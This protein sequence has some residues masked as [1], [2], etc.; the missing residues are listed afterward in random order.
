M[1]ILTVDDS[2][3]MRKMIKGAINRLG[4]EALEAEDGEKALATL[5]INYADLL[6]VLLD[7][8]MPNKSA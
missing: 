6:M 7:W 8:N 4:Y 1:K 3:I 5:A 2:G